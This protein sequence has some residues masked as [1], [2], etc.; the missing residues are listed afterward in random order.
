MGGYGVRG[1]ETGVTGDVLLIETPSEGEGIADVTLLSRL[2]TDKYR[3][4]SGGSTEA[5]YTVFRVN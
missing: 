4:E 1:G 2:D 5:S 3:L